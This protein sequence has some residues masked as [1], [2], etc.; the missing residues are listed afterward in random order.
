[1]EVS[2]IVALLTQSNPGLC[3]GCADVG[4][5]AKVTVVIVLDSLS[6][7]SQLTFTVYQ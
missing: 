1:M 6:S 7:K 2:K 5:K 4:S 3:F